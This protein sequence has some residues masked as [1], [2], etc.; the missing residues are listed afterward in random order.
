MKIDGVPGRDGED[1][2]IA[3]L[4]DDLDQLGLLIE[5]TFAVK[6]HTIRLR[7]RE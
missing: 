3:E 4:T 5:I 6:K 2:G 1:R 7:S